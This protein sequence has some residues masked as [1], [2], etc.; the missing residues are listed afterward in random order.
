VK[1]N[2]KWTWEAVTRDV[3]P[4]ELNERWT[5]VC[6]ENTHKEEAEMA[7][8]T[9][10]QRDV[11]ATEG[12]RSFRASLAED[13]R[14][15]DAVMDAMRIRAQEGDAKAAEDIKAAMEATLA[16]SL[17][18]RRADQGREE[19]PVEMALCLANWA[20]QVC[21]ALLPPLPV[22]LMDLL[23]RFARQLARAE[24]ESAVM[25]RNGNPVP[26]LTRAAWD[27]LQRE[28]KDLRFSNSHLL[29]ENAELRALRA[30]QVAELA[31]QVDQLRRENTELRNAPA[32]VLTQNAVDGPAY[33]AGRKEGHADVAA[34]LRAILD[35]KDTRHASI[36]GLLSMARE[37]NTQVLES[38]DLKEKLDAV[39]K[40]YS[41]LAN[42]WNAWQ[43][44]LDAG[45]SKTQL[46]KYARQL[47]AEGELA[48]RMAR[49]MLRILAKDEG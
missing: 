5:Q 18:R 7:K 10:E 1:L 39:N 4:G 16:E 8:H 36:E 33:T 38:K 48:F 45:A 40:L 22:G 3:L 20:E 43:A 9:K 28:N 31:T 6:N 29:K 41:D 12:A 35:P 24:H 32:M 46:A 26:A 15:Q 2:Q 14:V 21:P 47:G 27:S 13:A 37:Q 11:E 34:S 23:G 19:V 30:T 25:L 49:S 42:S 17:R 44:R